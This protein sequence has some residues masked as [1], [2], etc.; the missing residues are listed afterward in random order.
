MSDFNAQLMQNEES[1]QRLRNVVANLDE[2]D[3][4]RSLGGNWTVGL[5]F[6]H[7][8]FWDA[9]QI[10]ALERFARGEDF[11]REDITT[12]ATLESIASA[13]DAKSSADAAV[14]AA[15]RLDATLRGLTA[16]QLESLQAAGRGYAI[17]R[18]RHRDEHLRQVEEVIH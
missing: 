13:F 16:E 8:A 15:E 6:V 1:T 9:R 7:L 3:L 17:E 18:W 11:P 14:T 10:A 4:G 2:S 5:A 12:N